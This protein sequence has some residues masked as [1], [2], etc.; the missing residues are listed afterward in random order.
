MKKTMISS[1]RISTRDKR[2][3]GRI[4]STYWTSS[5][6]ISSL[7]N[8]AA[9]R[10]WLRHILIMLHMILS[11]SPWGTLNSR[12]S[13][14]ITQ[15]WYNSLIITTSLWRINKLKCQSGEVWCAQKRL[16]NKTIQS[17]QSAF[18]LVSPVHPA[19]MLSHMV[20]Q[21]NMEMPN[22]VLFLKYIWPKRTAQERTLILEPRLMS[23]P[24]ILRKK[25][26]YCSPSSD[27]SW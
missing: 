20:L 15:Q 16:D 25:R 13:R 10:V 19:I 9:S 26:F 23:G 18:S 8:S 21:P 2:S 1:Q 17:I 7:S 5:A 27:S 14:L 12:I 3:T 4:F 11:I 22:T 6:M 24:S